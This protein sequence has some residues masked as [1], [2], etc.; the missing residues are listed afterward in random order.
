MLSRL[1]AVL[2]LE[3]L[4][5]P[6]QESVHGS[7][8]LRAA[9]FF[10][11]FFDKL[12]KGSVAGVGSLL[13][14]V[15]FAIA[16]CLYVSL[17]L[18]QF[19]NDKEALAL[20]SLAGFALWLVGYLLG[21][22]ESRRTSA[23]DV[24]VILFFGANIV[25]TAAS[26][27]LNPAIHGLA[28]V[29]VY[30]ATYFYLTGVLRNAPRRKV[31]I[32]S[33]LIAAAFAV[34]LYG[35]YQYKIGVQPLATWEDPTV[36]T[37]G[38]R[39]YST[40]LNPNL[41]AGYLVPLSPLALALAFSSFAAKRPWLGVP[42][43][44][45][46]ATIAVATVLTGSRGGYIGLFVAGLAVSAM[47]VTKMWTEKPRARPVIAGVCIVAPVLLVIGLHFVPSFEQRLTS[48][49][50][51]SEHSSNAFRMNVWRSSLR[52]LKDNWWFGIGPGNQ[53]FRLA[54][55]L[56]MRSGFDALGTYC[57]P[58]ELAV[59]SGIF[60]L[61]SFGLLLLSLFSRGHQSFWS[62]S[63][64]PSRWLT[65]GAVAAI[66][67]MMAHGLVDTVFFRPQVQFIF[68]L[69]VALIVTDESGLKSGIER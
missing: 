16:V 31:F 9:G 17:A 40:L 52:M 8:V 18:R 55:G 62:N 23:V 69:A 48:I 20:F 33:S 29:L 24:T 53:V 10:K 57:V 64:G 32:V 5:R 11:A 1:A 27:Y 63:A 4:E 7:F 3:G 51:G 22:K 38:T 58:L 28:K 36:E 30:V 15:S 54:Y 6:W 60:G 47:A 68:W 34:S 21:G 67:G 66:V 2:S 42:A 46:T 41:L 19:A 37:K 61:S 25:A 59:E 50:A 39:I 14:S 13:Q 26:H 43:L 65:A 49:F 44:I 45:A 12:T 56:Y 35:L